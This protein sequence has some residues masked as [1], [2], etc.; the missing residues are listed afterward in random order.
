MKT[1]ESLLR[2]IGIKAN[3]GTWTDEQGHH[4]ICY[5]RKQGNSWVRIL[6]DAGYKAKLVYDNYAYIVIFNK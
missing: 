1:V 5:T 4:A 3:L 2:E 6:K